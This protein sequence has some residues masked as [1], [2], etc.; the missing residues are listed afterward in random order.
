MPVSGSV[1]DQRNAPC[2]G[3]SRER[4]ARGGRGG[5]SI[6]ELLS[7]C[8]ARDARALTPS[9]HAFRPHRA[10]H[11]NTLPP[12]LTR[13]ANR[14]RRAVPSGCTQFPEALYLGS[15]ARLVPMPSALASSSAFQR[16]AHPGR[17]V[18][19][20]ERLLDEMHPFIQY[21]VVGDDVGRVARHEQA[22]EGWV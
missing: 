8:A 15:K 11:T 19:L 13:P 20:G 4:S 7:G 21:T 2:V 22:L 9:P 17:Q 1:S 5:V 3:G 12:S 10:P 18:L 6:P 14:L 16:L